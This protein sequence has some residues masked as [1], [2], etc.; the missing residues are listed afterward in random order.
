[1][2][3]SARELDMT[4]TVLCFVLYGFTVHT[5]LLRVVVAI[6]S[7]SHIVRNGMTPWTAA[8]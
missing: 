8:N 4:G 6:S 7:G 2:R 5:L 3:A 1:M